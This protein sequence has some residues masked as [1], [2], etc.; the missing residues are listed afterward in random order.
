MTASAPDALPDAAGEA[1]LAACGDMVVINL[2]E[3]ADRR[4]EVAD[5]LRRIGLSFGHRRVR[6][7]E[8]VRP[9]DAGAFPS[10][11]ARGCFLSHL[12]ALRAAL[13]RGDEGLLLCEDDLNF[14][15]DLPRR[16]P[17]LAAAIAAQDW[18]ILYGFTGE[19]I[20]G[21]AMGADGQ[22]IALSPEQ[23]FP[24]THVLAF[25]RPA[26]EGLVPYLEAMLARPA[27]DPDGGPM[28]VDGAYCRFRAAR[29]DLRVLATRPAIGFQRSSRTSIA[30]L[31][32]ADRV[33][34][35][36]AIAGAARRLRNR[37]TVR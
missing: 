3:R 4:R 12:G 7:L 16:L 24:C 19:G 21:P 34:G 20:D 6:L 31:P 22:L 13:E 30:P 33:P 26:I 32:V 18:D 5:Q 28:H 17:G 11:G 2:P 9:P 27:G 29:P 36:R 25:R 35:L 37:L 1:L 10:V 8:A 23:R 14:A 15:H